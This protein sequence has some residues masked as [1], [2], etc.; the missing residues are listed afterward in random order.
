MGVQFLDE[1]KKKYLYIGKGV[2][3]SCI[4]TII[5]AFILAIIQTNKSINESILSLCILMTTMLSVIYGS[6]YST[7]KINSKGWLVGILVSFLYIVILYITAIIL[8]K[9]GFVLKD[10]WRIILAVITGALSGMLGIN[11]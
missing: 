7:R 8:G 4:I 2:F 1:F 11:I 3:R 5:L 9:S 6:I 10:L